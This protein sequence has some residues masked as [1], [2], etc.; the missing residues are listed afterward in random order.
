M[1]QFHSYPAPKWVMHMRS[2]VTNMTEMGIADISRN[3][4]KPRKKS[5]MPNFDA[6]VFGYF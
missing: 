3:P 5:V 2:R 6:K 1:Q 4:G